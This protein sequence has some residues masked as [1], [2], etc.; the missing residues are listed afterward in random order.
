MAFWP[1]IDIRLAIDIEL[2]KIDTERLFKGGIVYILGYISSDIC[3]ILFD[4]R[5]VQSTAKSTKKKYQMFT[6]KGGGF[7]GV[8]SNVKKT[9]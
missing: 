3:L 7:K 5:A 2:L 6:R 8:L 4:L 1:K 9:E